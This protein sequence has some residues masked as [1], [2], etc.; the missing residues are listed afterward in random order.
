MKCEHANQKDCSKLNLNVKQTGA[1]LQKLRS[2]R[3]NGVRKN[4]KG[5]AAASICRG[6]TDVADRS[7][8]DMYN[9]SKFC[10]LG[11][12]AVAALAYPLVPTRN[13][14][15]RL[16]LVCSFVKQWLNCANSGKFCVSPIRH[17]E[18]SSTTQS[19]AQSPLVMQI[20]P[21]RVCVL[22]KVYT[23]NS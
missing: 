18:E 17:C 14:E 21:L 7:V 15:N 4:Q 13:A 5:D 11:R 9:S 10:G 3:G 19:S 12:R 22:N 8:H 20:L 16:K 2:F 23:G 6:F 1:C